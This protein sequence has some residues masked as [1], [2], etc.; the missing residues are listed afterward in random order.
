MRRSELQN[1][2]D[3][4]ATENSSKQNIQFHE[5]IE[6]VVRMLQ[7]FGAVCGNS[8]EKQIKGGSGMVGEITAS[9]F[10]SRE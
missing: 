8:W 10:S 3:K 9:T 6:Y 2:Q 7:K 1:N 4:G 5:K